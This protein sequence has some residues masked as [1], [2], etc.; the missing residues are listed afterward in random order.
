MNNTHKNYRVTPRLAAVLALPLLAALSANVLAQSDN[1]VEVFQAI[2][3]S[4]ATGPNASVSAQT[5][6]NTCLTGA[7][8]A[9][10]NV[11]NNKFQDDCNL[12]VGGS[13]GDPIG[14]TGALN[15]LAADQVSAQNAVS[16]RRNDANLVAVT[17]R[18][19][20]LRVTSGVSAYDSG[21]L[22][23]QNLLIGTPNGG[24]ASADGSGSRLGMFATA[25]FFDGDEDGNRLQDGYDFDGWGGL[26]GMDYRFGD[27]FV[28][29]LALNYSD[30]DT[31]YDNN[32]GALESETWGIIAYGSLFLEGGLFFDG[33]LGFNSIDYDM[34]RNIQYSVGSQNAVQ[35]MTSSPDG[36]LWSFSVGGGYAF[37]SDSWSF[38]PSLRLDYLENKI[39]SYK[40]TSTNLQAT[41]GAMALA[42]GSATFE[43]LTSNLGLQLANAISTSNGV[44]VPQASVE[45]V[46]E[47]EDGGTGIRA[48]YLND[49]NETGFRV[50][51]TG[52]DS[53][54]FDVS[55][56]LSA[57]FQSGKS[58]FISY[59]TL[60]DYDGLSYNAIE[61]GFRIEL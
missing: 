17:Q 24:G 44:I 37:N 4:P 27:N 34:I 35:E 36:D 8:G 45:W 1:P 19:Q 9:S 50:R 11:A 61:L 60:L 56:G 32:R 22:I 59:R 23:A 13:P 3:D 52:L 15:D 57:Q 26:L 14:V 41:G 20:L 53:D 48:R 10:E 54:Y 38:T 16:V 18:M 28:A 55:L 5:I 25:K 12:L 47:F 2:I 58:A 43:S 49:I 39:S 21:E 51:T 31:D 30:G 40:E 7:N 6:L 46:H 33:T 42:M 29:G